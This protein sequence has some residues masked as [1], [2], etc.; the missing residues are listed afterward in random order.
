MINAVD[1]NGDELIDHYEFVK[2]MEKSFGWIFYWLALVGTCEEITKRGSDSL[3][4]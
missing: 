1:Q 2:L 4:L 3:I